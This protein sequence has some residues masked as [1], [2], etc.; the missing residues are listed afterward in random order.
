MTFNT[1]LNLTCDIM[2]MLIHVGTARLNKNSDN[3]GSK[4]D[5]MNNN[6]IEY[7]YNVFYHQFSYI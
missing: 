2:C 3:Q 6:R 1:T 4:V 5:M 7:K